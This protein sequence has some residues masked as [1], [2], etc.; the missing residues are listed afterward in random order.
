MDCSTQPR[1][2]V[3]LTLRLPKQMEAPGVG[4]AQKDVLYCE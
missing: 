4:M 1:T 3:C 2:I